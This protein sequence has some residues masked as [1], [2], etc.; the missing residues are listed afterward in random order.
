MMQA[1]FAMARP[2]FNRKIY[3]WALGNSWKLFD[4]NVE[5]IAT[6]QPNSSLINFILIGHSLHIKL[7]QSFLHEF[8]F[9]FSLSFDAL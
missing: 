6:K 9:V 2:R 7:L 1:G 8:F 5:T 4:E 3:G